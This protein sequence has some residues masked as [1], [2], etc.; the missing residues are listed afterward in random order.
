MVDWEDSIRCRDRVIGSSDY[1][2]WHG[3]YDRGTL[4][5]AWED[6]IRL[7]LP[8]FWVTHCPQPESEGVVLC[9]AELTARKWFLTTCWPSDEKQSWIIIWSGIESI[10]WMPWIYVGRPTIS[11]EIGKLSQ[12]RES[13]LWYEHAIRSKQTQ[14]A[15]RT[16]TCWGQC[17]RAQVGVNFKESSS[18][19]LCM[20]TSWCQ[21]FGDEADLVLLLVIGHRLLWY[22]QDNSGIWSVVVYSG[23]PMQGTRVHQ[24]EWS[25]TNTTTHKMRA[26]QG[27]LSQ[28][29]Y[30]RIESLQLASHVICCRR[31][32]E[33]TFSQKCKGEPFGICLSS[34]RIA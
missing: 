3:K 7:T 21:A 10:S 14:P 16:R 13:L 25:H 2:R 28:S 18:S 19:V 29:L 4:A 31:H 1:R 32:I 20:Q 5:N 12:I 24:M 11:E 33:L 6:E 9:S 23:T 30:N 15:H 34:A 26:L 8:Y 27:F 17:T 22:H